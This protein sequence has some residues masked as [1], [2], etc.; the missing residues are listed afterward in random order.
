MIKKDRFKKWEVK[1]SSL[2]GLTPV[3][4]RD[5]LVDCF[6]TEQKATFR[7]ISSGDDRVAPPSGDDIYRR[8]SAA[9]RFAFMEV[10]GDFT[11]PTISAIERAVDFLANRAALWGTPS[12][13]TKHNKA[14]MRKV[15]EALRRQSE[16][17][18]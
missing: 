16:N 11:K 1:S 15:V 6:Y 9:V 14:Q 2:I 12:E 13:V 7:A 4:A 3:K 18:L 8:V 5:L 10:G 17:R